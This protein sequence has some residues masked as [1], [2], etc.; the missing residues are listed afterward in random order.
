MVTF[1]SAA[2]ADYKCALKN[3]ILIST[4]TIE[5][6]ECKTLIQDRTELTRLNAVSDEC[7]NGDHMFAFGKVDQTSV[8]NNCYCCTRSD[9]DVTDLIDFATKSTTDQTGMNQYKWY[10]TIKFL[11]TMSVDSVGHVNLNS[12]NY[13]GQEYLGKFKAQTLYYQN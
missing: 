2:N 4:T 13:D 12:A 10:D 6:E 7:A 1:A 5:I 3:H 8:H 9:G 11:Q